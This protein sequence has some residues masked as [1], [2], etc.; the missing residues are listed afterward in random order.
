MSQTLQLEVEGV[1]GVAG[2]V[3]SLSEGLIVRLQVL[4]VPLEAPYLVLEHGSVLFSCN[5]RVHQSGRLEVGPL[6]C[7]EAFDL[8]VESLYLGE[9]LAELVFGLLELP[10][11]LQVDLGQ[12]CV[13]FAAPGQGFI[14]L[15]FQSLLV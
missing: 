8:L 5:C 12:F 10:V 13:Q 1:G 3:G 2:F 14:A 9:F 15:L 7:F 4:Q 11:H 6:L